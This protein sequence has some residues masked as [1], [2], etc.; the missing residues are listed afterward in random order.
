MLRLSAILNNVD[1]CEAFS[2]FIEAIRSAVVCLLSGVER[3][4]RAYLKKLQ[5]L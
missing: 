4:N 1:E 2:V 5:C 3:N